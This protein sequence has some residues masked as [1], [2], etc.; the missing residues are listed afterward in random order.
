MKPGGIFLP[1]PESG[2]G[3]A[4][5]RD[6]DDGPGSVNIL[7]GDHSTMRA[8]NPNR[9]GGPVEDLDE[10]E[11]NLTYEGS[12]Q[13]HRV[14]QHMFVTQLAAE[15]A[16]IFRLVANDLVLLLF[17]MMPRTLSRSNRISDSLRVGPEAT[18]LIFCIAGG[19]RMSSG[20]HPGQ[21]G[22]SPRMGAGNNQ[23]PFSGSIAGSNILGNFKLPK[24]DG[25]AR[26]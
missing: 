5:H 16:M 9:T 20:P 21:G 22:Y 18:V 1:S 2:R 15:A 12:L 7:G 24:F 3:I 11:I 25:N 10:F 26:Y 14:T 19:P 4:D 17:G 6:S 8:N 23:S 13:H